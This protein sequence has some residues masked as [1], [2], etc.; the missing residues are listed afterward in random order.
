[1]Q[2][3]LRARQLFVLLDAVRMPHEIT[4][5][6]HG[7]PVMNAVVSQDPRRVDVQRRK[8]RNPTHP[9][10]EPPLLE[11]GLVGRIMP[12]NEKGRHNQTRKD[13]QRDEVEDVVRRK[14]DRHHRDVHQQI[15]KHEPQ[16]LPRGV[17]I[18]RF[19]NDRDHFFE[20]FGILFAGRVA[21][22]ILHQ[23]NLSDLPK[24]LRPS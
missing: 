13:P 20:M 4:F 6:M 11:Q 24:P 3:L 1:M 5:L 15:P 2:E 23:M 8:H 19:G 21:R 16:P 12:D 9:I 18:T 14:Q 10:A 7:E 17:V 22:C